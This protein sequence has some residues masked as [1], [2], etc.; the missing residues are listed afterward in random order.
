[1][2]FTVESFIPHHT[3]AI[4]NGEGDATGFS[5]SLPGAFATLPMAAADSLF[6]SR[7]EVG[8][9]RKSRGDRRA[10]LVGAAAGW[11]PDSLGLAGMY[12]CVLFPWG[13]SQVL[14]RYYRFVGTPCSSLDAI[15]EDSA[16]AGGLLFLAQPLSNWQSISHH[17]LLCGPLSPLCP[18][19]GED[20]E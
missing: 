6:M 17:F 2:A 13:T 10:L 15:T 4:C 7:V 3:F 9:E 19:L 16:L 14:Q 1:M 12:S 11:D 18:Q 5:L 20:L 8:A